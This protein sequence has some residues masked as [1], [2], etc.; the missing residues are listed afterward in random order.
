MW[1]EDGPHA[2]PPP[3]L[4]GKS[5]IIPCMEVVTRNGETFHDG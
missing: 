2:R 3:R 5:A 1:M 4:P